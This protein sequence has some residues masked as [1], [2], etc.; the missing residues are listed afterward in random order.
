[1]DWLQVVVLAVVQGI[2]EFLPV[3][4][5]AHLILVPVLTDWQDQGLAFDVALHL[6]SLSAVII[7]FRQEIWQMVISSLAAVS[8]KGVNEDARLAFWVTLATVPV[9]IIGLLL[10][11]VISHYM[12]ST[13]IIGFSLMSFGLLLGYADWCKRGTR[14]EYQLCLKDVLIIGGAQVLALIPGTSRSGITITAA[15]MVGMSREGASRFSFLL[16]IPVIVL[17]GGLEAIGLLREPHS[18]DWVAMMVGTL[19]SGVSAYLCIHY[20]LVIIKKI[21]M[22]PFVIYRVLFGAWLLWFF[23]F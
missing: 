11:D 1:M 14:S 23:H 8:G 12:R 9:G 10:H 7:Y 6:G 13:L 4:S 22:Q 18:I 3:S 17:A 15:L 16:S 20:F 21:G 2:S 19:L 5:S